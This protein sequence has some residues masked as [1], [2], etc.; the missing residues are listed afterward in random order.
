[1]KANITQDGLYF[2]PG[3]GLPPTATQSQRMAAMKDMGP[4]LKAGPVGLLVYH[5]V[6]QDALTLRPL[7]TELATNIVQVLLAVFLLGQTSLAGFG[8]RWWF[9]IVAGIPAAI[10]TNVSYWTFYGFPATIR[11]LTCVSSPWVSWL[12]A[13]WRRPSSS[14]AKACPWQ[15]PL[16]RSLVRGARPG[17]S[18]DADA[19]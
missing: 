19:I 15:K 9:I 12:P 5:P 13:R 16:E 18:I 4:K 6:G 3:T 1:M 10:S 11:W 14:P 2:F 17:V 7:L 8:A